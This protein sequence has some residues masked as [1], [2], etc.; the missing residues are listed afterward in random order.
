MKVSS[1]MDRLEASTAPLN[2]LGLL[3]EIPREPKANIT[4]LTSF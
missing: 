1:G 3:G 2:A 4:V